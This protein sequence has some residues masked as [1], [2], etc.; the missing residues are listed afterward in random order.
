MSQSAFLYFVEGS[1]VPSLTLDELKEQLAR[2]RD[3]VSRTGQQL[4]WN[5]AEAAFPYTME[6]KPDGEGVW[7]YLKGK[8]ELYKYI[9]LGVGSA[10]TEESVR[11]YVQV[12]LPEG[13]THGD[14]SKGNELCK[15]L[16]RHLKAELHLFNGRIMYYNPR[17]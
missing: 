17:K 11:H 8:N 15:Y 7:F 13:S 10:K 3:Q 9:V 1:S 6:T 2:Y 12:V 14:K 16:A 4:D 5:Y